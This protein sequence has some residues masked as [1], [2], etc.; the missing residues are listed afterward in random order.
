MYSAAGF[1]SDL[2]R[3]SFLHPVTDSCPASCGFSLSPTLFALDPPEGLQRGESRCSIWL[4]N[5]GSSGREP[6]ALQALPSSKEDRSSRSRVRPPD[7]GVMRLGHRM[8][9][10]WMDGWKEGRMD[11]PGAWC[12][13]HPG[14]LHCNSSSARCRFPD[15]STRGQCACVEASVSPA[16]DPTWGWSDVSITHS[17]TDATRAVI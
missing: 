14:L 10:G 16:W 4:G 7:A 2:L 12:R 11:G 6:G 3:P 9:D 1:A 5:G 17:N 13:Q 8:V 15:S